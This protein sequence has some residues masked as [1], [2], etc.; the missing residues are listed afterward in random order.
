MPSSWGPDNLKIIC[1]SQSDRRE[2]PTR[3]MIDLDSDIMDVPVLTSESG[4]GIMLVRWTKDSVILIAATLCL[5]LSIYFK[6]KSLCMHH[7][8]HHIVFLHR[9]LSTLPLVLTTGIVMFSWVAL[10]NL[11]T[12]YFD[13]LV[14]GTIQVLVHHDVHPCHSAYLFHLK[15]LVA[16]L[17]L[18]YLILCP[19]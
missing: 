4:P 1:L 12:S 18:V 6:F 14:G 11:V 15:L 10:H 2:P 17:S 16:T 13:T 7:Y 3:I 9:S 5:H 8:H 19:D